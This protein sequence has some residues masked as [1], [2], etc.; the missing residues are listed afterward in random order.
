M[1][2]VIPLIIAATTLRCLT[3][4][5]QDVDTL[6]IKGRLLALQNV[7]LT[8]TAHT[9]NDFDPA[10][11]RAVAK[12]RPSDPHAAAKATTIEDQSFTFSGSVARLERW[13]SPESAHNL[14]TERLPHVAH[15]IQVISSSGRI[16]DLSYTVTASGKKFTNGSIGEV[17]LMPEDWTADIALGLRLYRSKSWLT[18]EELDS[19]KKEPS[20]VDGMVDLEVRNADG[21][22]HLLRFDPKHLYA[23]VYYR[24]TLKPGTFEEISNSDLVQIKNVWVPQRIVRRDEYIDSSGKPRDPFTWTLTVKSYAIDA[25][26]NTADGLAMKWPGKQQIYDYRAKQAIPVGPT[27]RPLSDDD[28]SQYL[29]DRDAKRQQLEQQAS[30]RINRVLSTP[31]TAPSPDPK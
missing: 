13:L 14:T 7:S 17:D 12:A 30:E 19:A 2:H 24:C 21:M 26:E 31:A 23:L 25:A 4:V 11:A 10:L 20:Q 16:E 6:A 1:R 18:P 22:T 3:A 15:E 29:N 28:I 27:T 5:A 9:D 8:Y